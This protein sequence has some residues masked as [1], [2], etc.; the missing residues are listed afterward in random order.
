MNINGLLRKVEEPTALWGQEHRKPRLLAPF[1]D[2]Y[3]YFYPN[4]VPRIVTPLHID[5]ECV[6]D[7]RMRTTMDFNNPHGF[8]I[9]HRGRSIPGIQ[10]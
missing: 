6:R 10:I 1:Y 2:G 3:I 5:H 4:L 8:R 7:T 9:V